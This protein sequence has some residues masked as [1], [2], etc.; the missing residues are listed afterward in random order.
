MENITTIFAPTPNE[1]L[2]LEAE[3]RAALN[4]Q[5]LMRAQEAHSR[6]VEKALEEGKT[7][8]IDEAGDKFILVE[9]KPE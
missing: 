2:K 4:H 9:S 5:L 8:I 1:R 7:G 6:A 3:Y